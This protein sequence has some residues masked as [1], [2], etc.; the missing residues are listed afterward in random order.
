MATYKRFEDLPVWQKARVLAKQA[1]ALIYGTRIQYNFKLK[2][3]M[4]SSSGSVMDNIAE[5]FERGGNK[6]FISFLSISKGSCGEFRSQLYRCV[7]CEYINQE[8]F[9]TLKRDAEVIS[10]ELEGLM[11]YLNHSEQKGHKFAHR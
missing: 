10:S 4:S 7:D 9:E 8:I 2:D 3:Q 5:G 11:N 6:E 1:D